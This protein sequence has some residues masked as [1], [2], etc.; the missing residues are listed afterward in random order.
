MSSEGCL[1]R[2]NETGIQLK[3]LLKGNL[4]CSSRHLEL[5]IVN[6]YGD[7]NVIIDSIIISHF[8]TLKENPSNF[9]SL[10]YNIW[11]DKESRDK[12]SITI[13]F[14]SKSLKKVSIVTNFDA[15]YSTSYIEHREIIKDEVNKLV[16]NK[17]WVS[18]ITGNNPDVTQ[19]AYS[20]VGKFD[21]HFYTSHI[22][23]LTY[24][25]ELCMK[26]LFNEV[27]QI[28][29]NS[30]EIIDVEGMESTI[31]SLIHDNILPNETIDNTM[32]GETDLPNLF[33]KL[34]DF[35]NECYKSSTKIDRV[36]KFIGSKLPLYEPSKPNSKYHL[37]I[38]M[39]AHFSAYSK[40]EDLKGIKFKNKFDSKDQH[41]GMLFLLLIESF[42]E[43]TN[44]FQENIPLILKVKKLDSYLPE[45]TFEKTINHINKLK[46]EYLKTIPIKAA[47][48]FYLDPDSLV[49][50]YW[51]GEIFKDVCKLLDVFLDIKLSYDEFLIK[52]SVISY[53]ESSSFLIPSH[54]RRKTGLVFRQEVEEKIRIEVIRKIKKELKE[55][56]NFRNHELKKI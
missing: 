16:G 39:M 25:F 18:T 50:E 7:L 27:E 33:Y 53:P 19:C 47:C 36:E 31:E 55:Y 32:T 3:N 12:T 22:E 48:F 43:L 46:K 2:T 52:Q 9:F 4:E 17:L 42:T 23:C 20:S 24:Q 35:S 26:D 54:K 30:D 38:H 28:V 49:P 29:L 21:T 51:N 40:L 6:P 14:L 11:K 8:K 13:T 5:P 15:L 34:I 45:C 41:I 10:E 56:D 44:L 37:L 1:T